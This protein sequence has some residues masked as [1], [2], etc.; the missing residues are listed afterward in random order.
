MAEK[1]NDKKAFSGKRWGD[2]KS[3]AVDPSKIEWA[4]KPKRAKKK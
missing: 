1:K 3:T 2:I 4:S